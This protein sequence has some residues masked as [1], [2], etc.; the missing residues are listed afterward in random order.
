MEWKTGFSLNCQTQRKRRN[1]KEERRRGQIPEKC[2][3][4]GGD[5][6]RERF[7]GGG[8]NTWNQGEINLAGSGLSEVVIIAGGE[9]MIALTW[10]CLLWA[11][12]A[13]SRAH[14]HA[15]TGGRTH[16]CKRR[17][18]RLPHLNIIKHS[19]SHADALTQAHEHAHLN[20]FAVSV[21]TD[22]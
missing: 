8:P 11:A 10:E 3:G 14:M 18:V 2:V 17:Q 19:Q 21:L 9:M 5:G 20:A 13:C 4:Q 16:S 22:N 15:P 6:R 12:Q 1:K 7:E